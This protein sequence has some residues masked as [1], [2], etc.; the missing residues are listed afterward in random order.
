[1]LEEFKRQMEGLSVFADRQAE[2]VRATV[3]EPLRSIQV[4]LPAFVGSNSIAG[5]RQRK[6]KRTCVVCGVWQARSI[7]N[8][9]IWVQYPRYS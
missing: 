7:E 5:I 6:E 9:I 3:I 8:N 2:G 4:R 1:M